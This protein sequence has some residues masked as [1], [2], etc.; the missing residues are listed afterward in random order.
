VYRSGEGHG[1]GGAR[2]YHSSVAFSR[3]TP[4]P[5][6]AL[7]PRLGGSSLSSGP[8]SGERGGLGSSHGAGNSVAASP[9]RAH[10][11][12]RGGRRTLRGQ[13][14]GSAEPGGSGGSGGSGGLP[15]DLGERSSSAGHHHPAGLGTQLLKDHRGS[16]GGSGSVASEAS[17]VH[18]YG[19]EYGA[20]DLTRNRG[21]RQIIKAALRGCRCR[22][23]VCVLLALRM[24]SDQPLAQR[25]ACVRVL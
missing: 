3:G 19:A 23:C 22:S 8:S 7:I 18:A 20:G 14:G 9:H 11:S 2:R 15:A 4:T 21:V 13:H 6:R 12:L 16:G 10:S 24:R 5:F 25:A 1:G 17:L